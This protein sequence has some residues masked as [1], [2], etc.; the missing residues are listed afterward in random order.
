MLDRY[1]VRIVC[2]ILDEVT[3]PCRFRASAESRRDTDFSDA[4]F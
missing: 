2:F 4:E 1:E 3:G